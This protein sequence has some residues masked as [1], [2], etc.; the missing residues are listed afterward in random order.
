MLALLQHWDTQLL[1]MI[2]GWH[3]PLLDFLMPIITTLGSGG[4][5]WIALTILLLIFRRTRKIGIVMG[6]SLIVSALLGNFVLKPF[7]ARAR[8]FEA[9]PEIP[10]I[11][12]QPTGYSFPSGHTISS[13]AAAMV[14]WFYS[15]KLALPATILAGA[16]GFSR[17]YLFCHY[18][19]DV[20]AGALLGILIALVMVFLYRITFGRRYPLRS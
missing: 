17:M 9:M 1:L 15:W 13:F 2:Q 19:S 18:P 3:N 12:S 10:M 4:M 11:I 6:L 14:L 5:L 8:P 20:L 16:I 7:I